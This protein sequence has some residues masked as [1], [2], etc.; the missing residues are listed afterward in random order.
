MIA[1]LHCHTK[2]S[3][4]SIGIDE[5]IHLAKRLH[6]ATLALTDHDTFAGVTRAQIVGKREGVEVIP[7]A[8]FSTID[9][10]SGKRVHILCYYCEKQDRL[11]GLCKK[12]GESRRKAGLQMIQKVMRYYPITPDM[13]AKRAQGSTNLYKTHIMRVLMDCGYAT[14]VYG[15]LYHKLFSR[16]EG[17]AYVPVSYPDVRD[18]IAQIHDARGIAVMAHPGLYDGFDLIDELAACGLDGLE[19]WHSQNKEGYEQ[20]LTD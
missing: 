3:D 19:V 12:T 1:D 7:G 17:I 8:E 11:E 14:Q 20:I 13:V 2:I 9:S 18:V 5:L 15:D 4:G 6:I 16:K 10:K